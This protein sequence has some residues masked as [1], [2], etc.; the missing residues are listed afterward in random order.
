[1]SLKKIL[2]AALMVSIITG[3]S[4]AGGGKQQ[5]GGASGK[6]VFTG[7]PKNNNA[8]FTS[9]EKKLGQ[10]GQENGVTTTYQAPSSSDEAVQ[11]RVIDDAINQGAN[12]VLVVPNDANSLVPVFQRA[13]QRNVVV[14]T[15]ESPDQPSADFDVEMIDN[16][17]YGDKFV[18]EIVKVIGDSGEYAIYVGSLTVPAHNIWADGTEAYAKSKYPNLK[19]V[20]SRFPVGEDRNV[21]R[22]KTLELIQTYPNLKGIICYGSEGAPGAG[23]AIRERSLQGKIA[24]VG[25][26]TPNAIKEFIKDGSVS[27]A[28]IWDSGDAS[29]AMAYLARMILDGKRAD[30]KQG[31]NIPAIG[32]PKVEG[33]NLIFDKPLVLDKGNVDNYNF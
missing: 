8:W 26:T 6:Y 5:S 16:N 12:A 2:L 13:K 11:A 24:V 10:Y 33:I 19:L 3:V 17:T 9:Y 14:I 22:Q 28:I 21:A 25:T 31:L 23:Q 7:I 18:D 29:Y 4:F 1:M 30:I 20:A 27:A 32:S 15:H